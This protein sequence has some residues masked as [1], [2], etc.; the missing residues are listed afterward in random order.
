MIISQD[1]NLSLE[2]NCLETWTCA[3]LLSLS[4]QG[5]VRECPYPLKLKLVSH[6]TCETQPK[7]IDTVFVCF[8][9]PLFSLHVE[10]PT[11]HSDSISTTISETDATQSVEI[12]SAVPEV[13]Q[14]LGMY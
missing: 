5:T 4:E 8:F 10:C 1:P 11:N 9:F 12:P 13:E 2:L 6:I 14:G 7:C 3:V